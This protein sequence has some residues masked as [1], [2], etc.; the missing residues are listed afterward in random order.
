MDC[1]A[2]Y[3]ETVLNF[4]IQIPL[5]QAEKTLILDQTHGVQ[6]WFQVQLVSQTNQGKKCYATRKYGL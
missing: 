5:I 2:G 6:V 3:V 4:T 1:D